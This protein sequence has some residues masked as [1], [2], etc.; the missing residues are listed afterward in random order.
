MR[1][2]IFGLGYV[3]TVT[4][5]GLASQGH[6]VVGVDVDR[7]KVDA[8][9]RGVTPVVEPGIDDLIE[10]S[11]AAGRLWATEDAV[12]ALERADVSLVCVG[13][14]SSPRGDTDLTYIAR[15]LADVRDAMATAA[16]PP[17]GHHAVVVRSTVPPGTGA[18]VVAPVFADGH[19]APGW[20]VGTAMCPEF[21]REGAGVKDFFAPPF[22]VL[23][24]SDHRT[25]EACT[26]LFSFIDQEIHQVDVATAEGLKYACNAFHAIK[27]AFANEMGRV[28]AP[29]DVDA[30][31]VMSIF[32]EDRKLNIAPTYLRPGFAFGGSC[33]PKDLRALQSLARVAGV[34]VPL[35]SSTLV[36]NEIVVRSLVD[37]VLETGYR[38]VCLLGLS[39]KAGTDDLRESPN[40]EAAER[41]VGKGLEVRIYDPIVNPSLLVGANLRH[42]ESKLAHV[43]RLLTKEASEALEG[44]E[45]AIVATS[46]K[47]AL[48]ALRA[49]DP[50]VVID[51]NGRLGD[52]V[53][54]MDGYQGVSW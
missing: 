42:L 34:D 47:E 48:S 49:A 4:A 5:A 21:L 2:A 11:V 14:P 33:L 6:D 12:E 18:S 20:S 54:A 50:M 45:V 8:I 23:G 29:Y 36:T 32:C 46:D 9:R 26:E 19:P 16:P 43:N 1:V 24:T 25:R 28:L 7:H 40:L 10:D 35:L 52:D 22:V 44:A 53:E 3:G 41:F 27:V 39:F 31:Q 13:T 51:L 38:K 17:S 30:R 37:R 15:A